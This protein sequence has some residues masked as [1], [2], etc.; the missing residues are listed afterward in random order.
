MKRNITISTRTS[1]ATSLTRAMGS[2][3]LVAQKNFNLKNLYD[4][5]KYIHGQIY[6]MD[7]R[8]DHG[9]RFK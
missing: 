5:Y 8:V 1:E 7:D 9:A 6:N 3:K 2:N 4:K